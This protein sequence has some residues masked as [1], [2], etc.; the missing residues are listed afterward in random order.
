MPIR[1]GCLGLPFRVPFITLHDCSLRLSPGDLGDCTGNIVSVSFSLL[2]KYSAKNLN[3]NDIPV[4]VI[5]PRSSSWKLGA[6]KEKGF[7]L[8][9]THLLSVLSE[10]SPRH[11]SWPGQIFV[12][13]PMHTVSFYFSLRIFSP[14]R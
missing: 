7:G 3:F 12:Y 4:S 13:L 14:K 2:K 5:L 9:A 10:N 1:S 8:L 6:S 11:I